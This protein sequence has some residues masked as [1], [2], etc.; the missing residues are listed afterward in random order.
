[1]D[2]L[3]GDALTR[4]EVGIEGQL[5]HPGIDGEDDGDDRPDKNGFARPCLRAVGF[6]AF[7]AIRLG[8]VAEFSDG[9]GQ[10]FGGHAGGFIGNFDEIGG[11]KDP[12]PFDAFDLADGVF[13][14]PRAGGAPKA[15]DLK[16]SFAGGV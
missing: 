7:R 14:E 1:V 10:R 15:A 16:G 11:K 5:E 12:A 2:R 6:R 13:D 9:R 8:A 3:G 4:E